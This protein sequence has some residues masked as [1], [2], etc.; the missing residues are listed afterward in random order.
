M[1]TKAC[2]WAGRRSNKSE[3]METGFEKWQKPDVVDSKSVT[4]IG[5]PS[6][7]LDFHGSITEVSNKR[8]ALQLPLRLH[9]TWTSGVEEADFAKADDARKF[10]PAERI[11]RVPARH[12]TLPNSRWHVQQFPTTSL[13]VS[14]TAIPSLPGT[15]IR[16]RLGNC[17]VRREKYFLMKVKS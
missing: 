16:R 2:G 5:K 14:A 9:G 15:R 13:G 17:E 6:E 4:L 10:V 8:V 12:E 11:A 7:T 3:N 1:K